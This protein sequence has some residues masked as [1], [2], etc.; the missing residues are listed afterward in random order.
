MRIL[1]RHII[2]VVA[3]RFGVELGDVRS[4]ARGRNVAWPRQYAMLLARELTPLS[5]PT[6][7]HIFERDHTTVLLGIRAAEKRAGQDRAL[8]L[9][10]EAIGLLL[11]SET[12][13]PQFPDAPIELQEAA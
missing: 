8:S 12:I 5:L 4:P 6:L 1:V 10:L 9:K 2:E 7:G 3:D 13:P 11:R